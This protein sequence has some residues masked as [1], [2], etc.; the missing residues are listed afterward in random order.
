[1]KLEIKSHL[2]P[3]SFLTSLHKTVFLNVKHHLYI[4]RWSNTEFGEN[5]FFL[6]F[7]LGNSYLPSTFNLG[8]NWPWK[9][10]LSHSQ[11]QGWAKMLKQPLDPTH[12]P[13]TLL[14]FSFY[15]ATHAHLP[16]LFKILIWEHS[17]PNIQDFG[18]FSQKDFRKVPTH[19]WQRPGIPQDIT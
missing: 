17:L 1:M 9:H 3:N 15:L 2:T 4:Q 11:T 10:S 14:W 8:F 7:F 18:S 12:V 6:L 5:Y 16:A 19:M 13:A